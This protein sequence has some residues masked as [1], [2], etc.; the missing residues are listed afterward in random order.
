MIYAKGSPAPS[1][2]TPGRM[3]ESFASSTRAVEL[4]IQVKT[5]KPQDMGYPLFD[6]TARA[7]SLLL[8][9]VHT[10]AYD[11]RSRLHDSKTHGEEGPV[12]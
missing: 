7:S 1:L 10:Q 8:N 4:K 3:A 5:L 9:I 2:L 6:F 11:V 12:A